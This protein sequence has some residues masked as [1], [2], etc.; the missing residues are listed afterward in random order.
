MQFTVHLAHFEAKRTSGGAIGGPEAADL[1]L[2]HSH[3]EIVSLIWSQKPNISQRCHDDRFP[4]V[5]EH[6]F[7]KEPTSNSMKAPHSVSC[8][9]FAPYSGRPAH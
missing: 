4:K 2:A 9:D 3:C 5:V 7:R 8:L 1:V 6:A